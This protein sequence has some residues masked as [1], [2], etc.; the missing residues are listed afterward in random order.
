[1][2]TLSCLY[3]IQIT[4]TY[5]TSVPP[6]HVVQCKPSNCL[7][8][9]K[10]VISDWWFFK[11]LAQ[12]FDTPC[13]YWHWQCGPRKVFRIFQIEFFLLSVIDADIIFLLS[14]NY[15]KDI[16]FLCVAESSEHSFVTNVLLNAY[17]IKKTTRP[18]SDINIIW[19]VS[20]ISLH[21]INQGSRTHIYKRT[22]VS[23][24]NALHALKF[25]YKRFIEILF[26]TEKACHN[27]V[28]FCAPTQLPIPHQSNGK[29]R[30]NEKRSLRM[31]KL[32]SKNIKK[33]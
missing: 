7:S 3:S 27:L 33:N 26:T 22:A 5:N 21:C 6:L 19:E 9:W 12:I 31:L 14:Q 28:S 15:S 11:C 30:T 24:K 16:L 13:T 17:L 10:M 8:M 4:K 29:T 1:M 20:I 25:Y 18:F 32:K 2:I 23:R